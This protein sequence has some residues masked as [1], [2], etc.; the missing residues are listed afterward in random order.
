MLL[1]DGETVSGEIVR[2][3]NRKTAEV[4]EFPE[5][6]KV[7]TLGD[8]WVGKLAVLVQMFGAILYSSGY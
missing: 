4:R 5:R 2:K 8:S 1:G 7:G 3:S 6:K